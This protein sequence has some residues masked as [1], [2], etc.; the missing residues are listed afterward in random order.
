MDERLYRIAA[1]IRKG[2]S[3]E[4]VFEQ[5]YIAYRQQETVE[6][7]QIETCRGVVP[8]VF[9]KAKA[10]QVP[11][12]LFINFHGGGFIR[13]ITAYNFQFCSRVAVGICGIVADVD[14]S[15]APENPFPIALDQS[16][17]VVRWIFQH[18]EE[19]GSSPEMISL[20]GHSAGSNLT[21]AVLMR[22]RQTKEFCPCLQIHDYGML[23]LAT[24]PAEKPGMEDNLLSV[25][26][27][28]EFNELYIWDDPTR[29]ADPYVSPAFAPT[30]WLC[31][32]PDALV[33]TADN[34]A[35]CAES[36]KYAMKLVA[37]G[38]KV[39]LR[40]FADSPHGFTVNC[41]GK[42]KEAQQLIVDMINRT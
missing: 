29:A 16:Y 36:E 38:T 31:G 13:P 2:S 1:E 30:E 7:L 23:D 4:P 15:L 26:R 19:L 17:D 25:K 40:R 6:R 27:C 9:H 32:Q 22:V 10:Y 21:A 39:I 34:D 18:A 20:G 8:V 35:F 24:D 37:A 5:E 33:I 11:C 28:R 12:R 41:K 42:W 3:L 14:Y